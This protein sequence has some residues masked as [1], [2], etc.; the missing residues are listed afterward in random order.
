MT[1]TKAKTKNEQNREDK[2]TMIAWSI[3]SIGK[4]IVDLERIYKLDEKT[5][6][7]IWN[8]DVTDFS[9]FAE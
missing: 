3:N 5:A 2:A 7:K 8:F 9:D 6:L 1:A 4:T